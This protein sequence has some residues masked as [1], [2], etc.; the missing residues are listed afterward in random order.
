MELV[1]EKM[2]N[3]TIVE[4]PYEKIDA[5]CKKEFQSDVGP[6]LAES[7]A[8]VVFDMRRVQFVDSAG[9]GAIICCLRELSAEG[10]DLKLCHVAK[11]VRGLFELVRLHRL[12]D[13]LNTPE[14]A[15]RAFGASSETE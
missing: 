11:P 8:K 2:G 9:I 14:E 15:V 1:I 4:L 10:G 12:L 5:S 3:V 7:Q 13:I 6:V